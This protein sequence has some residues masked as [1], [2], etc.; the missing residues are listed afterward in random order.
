MIYSIGHD[1]VENKRIAR[2]IDQFGNRFIQR[3]LTKQ[4]L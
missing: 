3:I 1:I 4:E 2:L